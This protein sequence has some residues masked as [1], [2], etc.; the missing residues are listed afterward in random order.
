MNETQLLVVYASEFGSTAEVAHALATSFRR[1]G[2]AVDVIS[3]VD[4]AELGP[5]NAVVVASPIYN[6]AWL[7]EAQ[8]F[9]RHNAAA[10]SRRAVALVVV[11]ATM[12][13]DTPRRRRGVLSFLD[14]LLESVPAVRPLAIGLFAGRVDVHQLPWWIRLRL[15]LTTALR[16][17]DNRDWIV[18]AQW[19]A[20]VLPLL[21]RPPQAP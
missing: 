14:P 18:I 7:P 4:V 1:G 16:H 9:V 8:Y 13:W 19:A 11:S 17:G 3:V 21:T 12:L 15:R 20:D 5:Y 2:A 10:L 6:G